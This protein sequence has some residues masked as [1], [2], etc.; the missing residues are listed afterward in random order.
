MKALIIGGAG[1]VGGYLIRELASAGWDV[2]VTCLPGEKIAADCMRYEL[3]ILRKE[4]ISAVIASSEPDVIF[5]LA[6]QS[7]VAVSWKNRD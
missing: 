2:E 1:F 6:A 7:S 3:D 5:H 4:D